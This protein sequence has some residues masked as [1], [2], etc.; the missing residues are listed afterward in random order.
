VLGLDRAYESKNMKS[1]LSN[2]RPK[3][4]LTFL[5]RDREYKSS[6]VGL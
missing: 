3:Y 1:G 6:I 4:L 5:Q 2:I